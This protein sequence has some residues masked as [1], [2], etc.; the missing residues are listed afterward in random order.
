MNGCFSF[1]IENICGEKC[2]TKLLYCLYSLSN[3]CRAKV[4]QNAQADSLAVLKIFFA[5][6]ML[7]HTRL[8]KRQKAGKR[9]QGPYPKARPY[10]P[11]HSASP[12]PCL[13]GTKARRWG[14]C[15]WRNYLKLI[16]VFS[17]YFHRH[18]ERSVSAVET[19]RRSRIKASPVGE[20]GE[21]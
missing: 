7:R 18:V 3:F 2:F 10:N 20:A 1:C 5:C 21:R 13:R 11:R 12:S 16:F 8:F 6:H 19:S 4:C 17:L 9:R 14:N 15:G